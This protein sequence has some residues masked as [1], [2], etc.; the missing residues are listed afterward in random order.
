[1]HLV[2]IVCQLDYLYRGI[3][4]LLLLFRWGLCRYVLCG[5]H[6]YAAARGA[7]CVTRGL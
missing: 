7:Y 6:N 1:M 2:Q 4:L 5:N 3:F